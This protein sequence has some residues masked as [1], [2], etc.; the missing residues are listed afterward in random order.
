M[1]SGMYAFFSIITRNIRDKECDLLVEERR[2]M[3]QERC[4]NYMF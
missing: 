4:G 3:Q 1:G 2:D